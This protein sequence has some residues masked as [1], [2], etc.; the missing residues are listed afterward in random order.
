MGC[1][2]TST[3]F[4][5]RDLLTREVQELR[6]DHNYAPDDSIRV[7]AAA[8]RRNV[9]EVEFDAAVEELGASAVDYWAAA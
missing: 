4:V 3:P 1:R 5:E 8:I 7:V 6:A 2:R 9:N